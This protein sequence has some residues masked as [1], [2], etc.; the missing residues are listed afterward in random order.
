MNDKTT[1]KT[2]VIKYFKSSMM[3]YSSQ[4]QKSPRLALLLESLVAFLKLLILKSLKY[5]FLLSLILIIRNV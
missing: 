1:L 5:F 4:R 2:K 3:S